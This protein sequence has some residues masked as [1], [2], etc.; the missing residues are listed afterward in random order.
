ME[1]AT[2]ASKTYRKQ[3]VTQDPD[4]RKHPLDRRINVY[5]GQYKDTTFQP[6]DQNDNLV[7][8]FMGDVESQ[9]NIG[10]VNNSNLTDSDVKEL[11][12]ALNVLGLVFPQNAPPV[13]EV[14]GVFGPNT[15]ARWKQFYNM[16]PKETRMLL[17]PEDNPL[18]DVDGK[19]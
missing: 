7:D 6:S 11:Q 13:L 4:A 1:R 5:Q 14:D 16:L 3:K 12:S 2:G 15:Y 17:K 10:V 18:L 19:V 9:D 8:S